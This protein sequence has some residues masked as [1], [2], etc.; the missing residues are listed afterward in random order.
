MIFLVALTAKDIAM[1]IINA[2]QECA[3][4]TDDGKSKNM[5]F[6][7]STWMYVAAPIHISVIMSICVLGGGLDLDIEEYEDY[8]A[9][10]TLSCASLGSIFL[11]PWTM[12]G[13]ELQ[14]EIKESGI[15]N[16]Q[17]GDIMLSW[18]ILQLIL[19]I[20]PGF[21]IICSICCS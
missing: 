9:Y 13:W 6:G 21:F 2:Q 15:N 1:L 10:I 19:E 17:C 18:L 12:V 20:G 3:F 14:S 4:D 5:I 7:P 8:F 11:V 16:K